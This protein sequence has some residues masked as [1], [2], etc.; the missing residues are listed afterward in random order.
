MDYCAKKEVGHY[1][2][3]QEYLLYTT[4]WEKSL[5]TNFYWKEHADTYFGNSPKIIWQSGWA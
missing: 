4:K 3:I 2:L 5:Y 1:V